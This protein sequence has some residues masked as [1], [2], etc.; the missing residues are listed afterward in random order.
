MIMQGTNAARYVVAVLGCVLFFAL[1]GY[2]GDANV[3][4]EKAKKNVGPV[5]T[6]DSLSDHSDSKTK[7]SLAW[8]LSQSG[9]GFVK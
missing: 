7:G 4:S 8:V 2:A 5:S 9:E 1:N 3:I 6:S